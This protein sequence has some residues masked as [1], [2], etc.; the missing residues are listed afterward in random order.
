MSGV[1]G[2][3]DPAHVYLIDANRRHHT[4]HD[5]VARERREVGDHYL[6]GAYPPFTLYT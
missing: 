3:P 6:N 4:R 5:P 1:R 2:R